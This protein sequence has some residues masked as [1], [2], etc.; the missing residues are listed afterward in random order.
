MRHIISKYST[1]HRN[2]LTLQSEK[3]SPKTSSASSLN[4]CSILQIKGEVAYDFCP[5]VHQI[6]NCFNNHYYLLNH[7]PT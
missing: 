6:E 1:T 7:I 2:K 4:P 5:G 3:D